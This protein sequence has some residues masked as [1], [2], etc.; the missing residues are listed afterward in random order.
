MNIPTTLFLYLIVDPDLILNII[1]NNTIELWFRSMART[2]VW[3][4]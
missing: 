1:D 4:D 2:P 3:D